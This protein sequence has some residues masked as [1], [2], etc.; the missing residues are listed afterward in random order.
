VARVEI[1]GAQAVLTWTPRFV[2]Y[3]PRGNLPGCI[4]LVM[5]SPVTLKTFRYVSTNDQHH[6]VSRILDCAAQQVSN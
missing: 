6:N 2:V 3:G 5:H 1:A 4:T